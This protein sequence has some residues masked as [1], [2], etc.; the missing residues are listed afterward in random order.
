MLESGLVE[1]GPVIPEDKPVFHFDSTKE[2]E[3]LDDEEDDDYE[4][5]PDTED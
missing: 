5:F 3:N 2:S 4:P 1:V